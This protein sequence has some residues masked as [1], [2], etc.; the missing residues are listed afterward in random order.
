MLPIHSIDLALEAH[1]I[2]L[3]NIYCAAFQDIRW[4][5]S[6]VY[7]Q[8]NLSCYVE[9]ETDFIR[10]VEVSKDSPNCRTADVCAPLY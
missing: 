5:I 4:S 2:R 1:D 3:L 9:L 10:E 8:F 7:Y 6:I